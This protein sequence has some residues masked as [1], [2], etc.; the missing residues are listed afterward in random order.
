MESE[1]KELLERAKQ[2]FDSF[3]LVWRD[4][5]K[6]NKNA[7]AF[8]NQLKSHLIEEKYTDQWPGTKLFGS[9]AKVRLYKVNNETLSIL[10][11]LSNVFEFRSPNYPEDLAFY[12]KGIVKFTS[13]SHE[14][15]FWYEKT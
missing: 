8:S 9:M 4:Q 1:Y 6:Y 7:D 14:K 11:N 3:S 15:D 12:S 5:L 13:I 10:S 2:E